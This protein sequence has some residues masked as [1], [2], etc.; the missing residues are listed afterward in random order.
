MI[1][2]AD[3]SKSSLTLSDV[4]IPPMPGKDSPNVGPVGTVVN[5]ASEVIS[6]SSSTLPPPA[7]GV[8]VSASGKVVNI[9]PIVAS[10]ASSNTAASLFFKSTISAKSSIRLVFL[11]KGSN[12]MTPLSPV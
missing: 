8:I 1:F 7:T 9:L 11:P 2:P 12:V 4:R 3:A 5:P 10:V 6:P